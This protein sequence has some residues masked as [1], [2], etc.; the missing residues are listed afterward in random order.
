MFEIGDEVI[1][2]RFGKGVVIDIYD[3]EEYP[4][5]V[6]F[7]NKEIEPY[8]KDGKFDRDDIMATLYHKGTEFIIKPAKPKRSKWVNIYHLNEETKVI[9]CGRTYSTEKEAKENESG[10]LNYI[11]TI[12]I[13]PEE[14]G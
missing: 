9:T 10:G 6:K 13:T 5:V 14:M 4:I 8:A 1:D 12:E 11:K 3:G 7:N 2:W